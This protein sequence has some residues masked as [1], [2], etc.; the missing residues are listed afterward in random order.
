[1]DLMNNLLSNFS[2]AMIEQFFISIFFDCVN[3]QFFFSSSIFHSIMNHQS[4][5]L[6]GIKSCAVWKII[7]HH[8]WNNFHYFLIVPRKHLSGKPSY[9]HPKNSNVHKKVKKS[10]SHAQKSPQRSFHTKIN[11][12]RS[13][14]MHIAVGFSPHTLKIFIWVEFM[15]FHTSQTFTTILYKSLIDEIYFR[16]RN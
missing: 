1:M 11:W 3:L 12:G 10:H 6:S 4:Y 5:F 2:L 8:F 16:C 14:S 13:I 15:P 9:I 7:L